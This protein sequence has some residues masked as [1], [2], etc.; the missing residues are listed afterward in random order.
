MLILALLITLTVAIVL[1]TASSLEVGHHVPLIGWVL[2]ELWR[3]LGIAFIVA[4]VVAV[5]FELYRGLHHQ[6]KSMR[7]VI[8][9]VMGEQ[10]TPD[11]WLELK[12]LIAQKQLL[13]RNA[14]IRLSLS[15]GAAT[16]RR[17]AGS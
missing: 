8:D 13:R 12:D 2:P 4:C 7:D 3:D 1:L 6:L 15:H 14:D 16:A 10:I 9:L 5:L 11:I 17:H